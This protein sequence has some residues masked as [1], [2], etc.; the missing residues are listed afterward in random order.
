MTSRIAVAAAAA[1]L[2]FGPIAAQANTRA[3]D[4][5]GMFSA[6][7]AQPGAD[8]TAEGEEVE[9]WSA[10]LLL[11]LGGGAIAGGILILEDDEDEINQS[12]GAN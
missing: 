2:A 10:L 5:A 8:R 11:L 3:S 9:G 4:F 6:S 12:P 7:A 1:A